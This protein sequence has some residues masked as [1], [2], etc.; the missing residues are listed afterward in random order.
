MKDKK[1]SSVASFNLVKTAS[2]RRCDGALESRRGFSPLPWEVKP[3]KQ[4]ALRGGVESSLWQFGANCEVSRSCGAGA[5]AIWQLEAAA[6][7][8]AVVVRPL[9]LVVST[10][11][12]DLDIEEVRALLTATE[13]NC[14][15]FPR[16]DAEGAV[17]EV[18][19]RK[20]KRAIKHSAVVVS[21]SMRGE[22]ED[23]YYVGRP[24][25]DLDEKPWLGK[26]RTL[27]AFGRATSDQ[28]LTAAIHDLAVAPSLQRQGLGRRLVDRIVRE[29]VRYGIYDVSVMSGA[30]TR[31]FFRSCGFSA[32][33]LGSTSMMYTAAFDTTSTLLIQAPLQES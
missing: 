15:Q 23:D 6:R 18:D 27:V 24:A 26:K 13:Q 22:L 7:P 19:V 2:S 29:I 14:E 8:G 1:S 10:N 31:P 5:R 12:R 4:T 33:V 17:V 32:D 16:L 3:V 20:L 28:S 11:W 21:I 9:E 30:Q 25:K